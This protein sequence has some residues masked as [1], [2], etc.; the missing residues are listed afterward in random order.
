[1]TDFKGLT[2]SEDKLFKSIQRKLKIVDNG[3]IGTQTMNA[4]AQ[5]VGADC[6]PITLQMYSTPVICCKDIVVASPKTGVGNFKNCISGSFSDG[7]EPVSVMVSD[8]KVIRGHSCHFW[9]APGYPETVLYKTVTGEIGIKRVKTVNE[10]PS[11]KWAVGGMGLLDLYNPSA[12]GFSGKFSDVLRKTDHTVIG[13]KDGYIY[14]VYLANMTAKEVNNFC[15]NKL[16]LNKAVMLDGGHIA[17]I[18]GEEDFAK[19]NLS[20]KQLYII[21]GV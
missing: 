13:E 10:L 12:E 19:K 2:K 9:D 7:V 6:Y 21:Q 16:M 3:W 20:Q 15:K 11:L 17:A 4:I 18:N 14:L 1:M 5:A 8:G